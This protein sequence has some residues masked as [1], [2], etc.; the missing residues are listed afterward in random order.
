[1]SAPV[2]PAPRPSGTAHAVDVSVPP[3]HTHPHRYR[4]HRAGI[5][6]V[7]Q[8]DDQEFLFGDG[9]LLLRGKNGA[10]KSKALE[11]LLPY[12][13]DGDARALDATGT[14]RTTLAWLMLDGYP[15]TNRLGYLWVEFRRTDGQDADH[16][17]TIGAAIRASHSTKKAT[18]QFFT[19]HLRVGEE[20]RL[21]SAGQPLPVDKLRE[22]LGPDNVHERAVDHR[23]RVARE[24]FGITDPARFRN[25]THLLH[26]L[27]RPTI[28]DRIESGGIAIVL[29]ET[30]PG[31]D[32]E[33]IEKVARNLDDLDTIRAELARLEA[34][35]DA[36]RRFL[37]A[38]RGYLHGV[39][40]R[41]AAHVEKELGTLARC[42]KEAG[43]A[44]AAASRL[45][46]KERE[47]AGAA[48]TWREQKEAAEGEL[49]AL[50]SSASYHTLEEL[51]ERRAT[52][53]ALRHAARAAFGAVRIAHA[54]ERTAAERLGTDADHIGTVLRDLGTQ[55]RDA[56][57][58]AERA[59]LDTAHL[60]TPA[61]PLAT[62]VATAAQVT[63][64]GPDGVE[65]VLDQPA[66]SAI[67]TE[68]MAGELAEWE[69][70]L[71]GAVSVAKTRG[72][73]AADLERELDRA[74]RARREADE[75]ER[76][77][78][79]LEGHAEEARQA[80]A[81]R[82][83]DVVQAS[84]RYAA[85]I[86]QW[87]MQAERLAPHA[88]AGLA[89]VTAL[90]A[91]D[92]ADGAPQELRTLTADI[93]ARV[94][95]AAHA[96][97]DPELEALGA[98]RAEA[99]ADIRDITDRRDEL[100]EERAAWERR[101]DPAPPG[102]RY[103]DA[104]RL[105]DTGAP[106]Y[107]LVDFAD[108]VG[109][110]QA[111]GLEAALEAAGLLDGWVTA[112][113]TVLD[114]S[115]SD[116]LLTPGG[117]LPS[118]VRSL[119]SVLRPIETPGSG[120]RPHQV[121]AL[122]ESIA[123]L[124]PEDTGVPGAVHSAVG[125]DGTWR[126]GVARGRHAKARAE[127]V[128]AEVR[129]ATRRRAIATLTGLIQRAETDLGAARQ[130]ASA[131]AE[132]ASA[133]TR[134]LRAVPRSTELSA[135]WGQV[136]EAEKAAASFAQKALRAADAAAGAR[137][138]A[139]KAR[140]Q[141]EAMATAHDLPTETAGLAAVRGFLDRLGIDLP[142]LARQIRAVRER[143]AAHA[144]ERAA[145]IQSRE[146]SK[147]AALAYE[148]HRAKLGLSRDALR[149]LE[150]TVGADEQHI[151]ALE[152]AAQ[153]RAEEATRALPA[154]ERA[155]AE[156]HD[157]VIKAQLTEEARRTALD[158]QHQAVIDSGRALRR[159]LA[160]REVRRGAALADDESAEG[161]SAEGESTS[162]LT[163]T[164]PAAADVRTR[165][166]ALRDLSAAVHARL[167]PPSR[168]ASDTTILN[169]HTQLRDQL[170]GGYD[171][172]LEEQDGIKVCRLLDDHGAHDVALVAR[173]I[174]GRSQEARQRLSER[175][176]EV[177]QR[178]LLGEL[179]DNL[180][181]QVLAA[182]TLV[183]ALNRT[184]HPVR[185]SHGLGVQ[186][187]WRLRDDVEADVRAAVELLR[188]PS[189]LRTRE[190]SKQLREVLQ[191]RIEEVRRAD[192]SAGYGDHLRA[193]L[194]YRSWFTFRTLVT[195]DAA[196]GR[197]RVLSSR[198]GLSQGEQR[199]LSY[200]V[201]FASAAAHF[202]TLAD[203]AP[204]TP[205]LILLDDAFAKV[206]EPTHARLG[207]ILVDLD[208]DFV[209]TS[210]RLM[211]NWPDV[212]ALHIYECLRDP[213]ARGVATLHYEWNGR[214]RRLISV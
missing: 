116:T 54:S 163:V 38:Y 9:R 174:A 23:A 188:S 203:A 150:E 82:M 152:T 124:P 166:Q 196:P 91:L 139:A 170:A 40:R 201:L 184:L 17:L 24:L 19:T 175:E 28:G 128:G 43:G 74:A 197:K 33:V 108:G 26:R 73:W 88:R 29:S 117:P 67:D 34:T 131:L 105:P 86:E 106:L 164:D 173:R 146:V 134:V 48:E 63:L 132:S 120:V 195:D 51:R 133:L 100:A 32:E 182:G 99:V 144:D 151:L 57:H 104:P 71:S 185:T 30:L 21:V 61:V 187:E 140:N 101:T 192:P 154:A 168:D 193:A 183:D 78:S 191:R 66:A 15:Q 89:A 194:D 90:V 18:P 112:E 212:P 10:G 103:R 7:W 35:D 107:R 156:A 55:H 53:D 148:E 13:L 22:R 204:H 52:V 155:A 210:E 47:L 159:A 59:G 58:A 205:R 44:A 118:G 176:R 123:L 20:L 207:R 172:S 125:L 27:R 180:S 102:S 127:Y 98:A 77:S 186:L 137:S 42:R 25:L 126:L 169:R 56:A 177:F 75:A 80:A 181:A 145:H 39:L 190:Q 3:V 179:G 199:V 85:A 149:S 50:R 165:I 122:L 142:A 94:T 208:L 31:L 64:E 1:M 84:A 97:L 111:A 121:T 87:A 138:R 147:D 37:E 68:A 209:L 76:E 202:T 14:G 171:A 113:G 65:A 49:E 189:S 93:D 70:R 81:A 161:S 36:L 16:Y 157:E 72:R 11:I 135:L 162:P 12:L 136:T 5:R 153:R 6:N 160:M 206:D 62:T 129:A 115:T 79:R 45:R 198:T 109:D 200:L 41:R 4:L 178:Y 92:S 83:G 2:N 130:R 214:R 211:G 213:H 110:G 8:Y 95:E 69:E 119:T 143:L 96:A 158:V 167:D 46:T 141:A 114:P 60:G